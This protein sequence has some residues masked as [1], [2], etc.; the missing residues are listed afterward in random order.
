MEDS[1]SLLLVDDQ[2]PV[3][4]VIAKRRQAAHPHALLLGCG[5]LVADALAGQFPLELGKGQ[6]HVQGQSPHARACV[7]L[8]R[9]R[10]EGHALSVKGFHDLGEVEQRTGQPVDLVDHDNVNL[11][12]GNIAEKPLQGRAVHGST[13]KA[14]VVIQRRQHR[15]AFMLLRENE[16]RA[17]FALGVERVERLLQTL[18]RGFARID[19]AAEPFGR[20]SRLSH[21]RLRCLREMLHRARG[22]RSAGRTNGCR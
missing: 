12:L 4:D 7:E 3:L 14:A 18:L 13:G 1:A 6:Q 8:L 17:S 2:L 22:Q 9:D 16:G 11:A 19:R 5:N 10:D 20:P 21:C 15:P